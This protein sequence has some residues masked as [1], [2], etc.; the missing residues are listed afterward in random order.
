M[1]EKKILIISNLAIWSMGPNKG[2]SSFWQTIQ[3]YTNNGWKVFLISGCDTLE[4]NVINTNSNI[5]LI[6][7]DAKLL[8]RLFGIRKL[9]FFAKLLWWIYLQSKAF[10]VAVLIMRK[11]KIDVFYGYELM[12]VPAAKLLSVLYKKPV[13]S[14]FQGTI[15]CP[16]IDK[17]FWKLRFW[18]HVLALTIPTDLLIMTNDGTR[19]D[20]VL[21]AL[22]VN[23]EKVRFWLNGV[24]LPKSVG[25][26][27]KKKLKEKLGIKEDDKILLTI[28]RLVGW[29]KVDRTIKAM[30]A[31]IKKYPKTKLLIVGEGPERKCLIKMVSDLKLEDCVLFTGAVSRDELSTY[32]NIADIFISLYDLSNVG[33][34]LLEAMSYGKCIVTLDVGDTK[35]FIKHDYNGI[36]IKSDGLGNLADY[37]VELLKD[38]GKCER[39]GKNAKKFAEESFWTWQERMDAEENEIKH[40]LNKWKDKG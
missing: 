14:R 36:L 25:D 39:L 2:A 27:E 30:P 20:R 17:P 19:G 7:F 16:W 1:M 32:Y 11:E 12:G 26:I 29:K 35:E 31:I 15:L 28:S 23:P 10:V 24:D 38:N 21:D 18:E 3:S 9:G 34:P 33:N 37:V 13:I 40:I 4:Y 8:K 6:Q 5:E 22:R